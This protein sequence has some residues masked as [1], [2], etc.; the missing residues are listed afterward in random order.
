MSLPTGGLVSFRPKLRIDR[1]SRYAFALPI[2]GLPAGKLPRMLVF[3]L[4]I[5]RILVALTWRWMLGAFLAGLSGFVVVAPYSLLVK[6][7]WNLAL[8][9]HEP[10]VLWAMY[11][12]SHQNSPCKRICLTDPNLK[13]LHKDPRFEALCLCWKATQMRRLPR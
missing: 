8:P 5:A 11:L 7:R 9:H 2:H 3:W 4:T 13:P 10:W 6:P 1:L 12:S